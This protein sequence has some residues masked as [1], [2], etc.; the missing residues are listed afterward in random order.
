MTVLSDKHVAEFQ[1]TILQ[2]HSEYGR[3]FLW[4]ETTDPYH[5]LVSEFMLQQTQT[6]R[7]VK[8][9]RQW[10]DVF[11]TIHALATAEFTDVLHQ[12]I[13]LGYNRRARF[14]HRTAKQI[15]ENCAG[16]IPDDPAV[17]QT[18]P[19]IGSYTANAVACFAY[20]RP[21]VFIETNIRSVFI[22]FFF[23]EQS[24]VSD[25]DIFPLIKTTLYDKNPRLWYYAL[26]DYGAA[27][28][29]KTSNPNRKSRHYTKQ[30]AFE[31]SVRQA[32]GEILRLLLKKPM[33]K[34]ELFSVTK[35]SEKKLATALDGLV[36]DGFVCER[37]LLYTI[38]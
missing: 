12:W 24:A 9:Y 34:T 17:L 5:V 31:G 8:K 18:F 29:K 15:T 36:S 32:R 6:D 20:N 11:P 7:V 10:L 33:Y 4:R 1:K 28:K 30:S 27:L 14:L 25:L 2:Y 19:G 22:F 21:C 13:G 3:T 35:L 37:E 23:R 38:H 26:M 16:V